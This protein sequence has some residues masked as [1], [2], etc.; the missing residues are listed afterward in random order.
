MQNAHNIGYGGCKVTL[1][2][3]ITGIGA[4]SELDIGDGQDARAVGRILDDHDLILQ[5][6]NIVVQIRSG[7][8][9]TYRSVANLKVISRCLLL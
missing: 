1:L 4:V 8:D 6:S 3:R 7:I 9:R 2:L 5:I